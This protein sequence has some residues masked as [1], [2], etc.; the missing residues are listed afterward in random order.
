MR[1]LFLTGF[2]A[3]FVRKIASRP[4]RTGH[5]HPFPCKLFP[6]GVLGIEPRPHPGSAVRKAG[7]TTG[8]AHLRSVPKILIR[9]AGN[10]T[11][12]SR[13]RSVHT[14]GVLHPVE[15]WRGIKGVYPR[16][17]SGPLRRRCPAHFLFY[18]FATKKQTESESPPHS[19][20]WN[21]SDESPRRLPAQAGK[22]RH[23]AKLSRLRRLKT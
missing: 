6:V 2:M 8:H 11:Q 23:S 9:G 18:L 17:H 22:R 20:R 4:R 13:T 10:R 5:A 7:L 15:S 1:P 21:F 3:D 16:L 12:F 14:A 19:P